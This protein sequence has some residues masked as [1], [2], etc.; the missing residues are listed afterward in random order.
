MSNKTTPKLEMTYI[1]KGLT[2]Y[3]SLNNSEDTLKEQAKKKIRKLLTAK[4]VHFLLGAGTSAPTIPIMKDL[5]NEFEKKELSDVAGRKKI[6]DIYRAMKSGNNLEVILGKLCSA[7]HAIEVISDVVSREEKNKEIDCLIK[8][9]KLF[10]I[11]RMNPEDKDE[12]TKNL[13]NLYKKFY[14]RIVFRNKDLARV[15][16]F[17]TNYDLFNEKAL[18]SLHINYNNGFGGGLKRYFNP[19][20]FH[21]TLSQKLDPSM[22]KFEPIKEMVYLYKLHGSISWY[23][24]DE[25]N[26][27]LFDIEEKLPALNDEEEKSRIL[28]YPSPLKEGETL[29]SPYSDL[30]RELKGKLLLHHSVLFIIGYSFSD[31]HIN[32]I[33]YQ[34]MTVNTSLSIFV[35]G[36]QAGKLSNSLLTSQGQNDNQ[37]DRRLYQLH[38]KD[39]TDKKQSKDI[40]YFDYI[41]EQLLPT[42]EKDQDAETLENFAKMIRSPKP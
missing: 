23:Q 11:K 2:Q 20:R 38:G 28:I 19:S 17:T 22:E 7:K 36:E 24:A 40:H 39:L 5:Q 21:Y 29:A 34:A 4:N 25:K 33:I 12:D 1:E 37:W 14:T 42:E 8:Y 3:E 16:V 10:L 15:N 6:N 26:D 9:I 27:A 41:V 32:R 13:L 18:D 30:M 31:E 35:F